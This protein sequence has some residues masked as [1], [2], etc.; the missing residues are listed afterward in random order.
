[1]YTRLQVSGFCLL[2]WNLASI[3]LIVDGAGCCA[4]GKQFVV[5]VSCGCVLGFTLL[6]SRE[7]FWHCIGEEE[8]EKETGCCGQD[9]DV[10]PCSRWLKENHWL[11]AW[12][13]ANESQVGSFTCQI[14]PQ[15]NFIQNLKA[16]LLGSRSKY[17]IHPFL[18][19]NGTSLVQHGTKWK[20]D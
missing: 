4:Q 5:F 20:R 17:S 9:R 14:S 13:A 10:D 7:R 16:E 18:V 2:R 6:T 15:L 8:K 12:A 3:V 11:A 1:M 19:I